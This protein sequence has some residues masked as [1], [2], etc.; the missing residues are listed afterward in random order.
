MSQERGFRPRALGEIAIRCAD[1]AA[2]GDFYENVIGLTCLH[3]GHDSAI[4]FFRIADGFDGHTQ[5]LALFHRGAAPRPGLHPTGA[6]KPMT[7]T[8]SSL[9]HIALSLPFAEQEA[10]MRWYDQSA[11]P[12]ASNS[13]AG[14]VGAACLPR[15]PRATRSNWWRMMPRCW[16]RPDRGAR[17]PVCPVPTNQ[18]GTHIR[19]CRNPAGPQGRSAG[20]G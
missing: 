13:S 10:V 7:E 4:T 11:S 8:Q 19:R 5:V 14:S 18:T 6:D 2:M 20:A 16:I 15:T 9:H 3:G 12:I 1:M 17:I